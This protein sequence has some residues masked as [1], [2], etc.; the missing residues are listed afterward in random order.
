LTESL[1]HDHELVAAQARQRV[2]FADALEH[3]RGYLFEQLIADLM[4][5]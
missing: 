4:A 1:D 2:A 5:E 3:A